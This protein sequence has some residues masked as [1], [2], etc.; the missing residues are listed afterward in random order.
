ARGLR[1]PKNR[2][3]SS[4][5]RGRPLEGS[6]A[7]APWRR[8]GHVMTNG[9][10]HD[11]QSAAPVWAKQAEMAALLDDDDDAAYRAWQATQPPPPDIPRADEHDE[12]LA[13]E[14]AG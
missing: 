2:A 6:F 10:D 14:Y 11:E 9:R 3:A 1:A 13:V 4:R 7:I 8:G 5:Q 12:A